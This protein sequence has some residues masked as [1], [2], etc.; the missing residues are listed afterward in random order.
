MPARADTFDLARLNL[1]S[2]EGRR[3]ELEVELGSFRFG[4]DGYTAEPARV[5]V[6]LDISRMTGNGWSLRLRFD[7]ALGGPCMRCLGEA[8]PSVSVD[9]REVDQPGSG[10]ELESPYVTGEE[11]DV[12]RWAH[13]AFALALPAQIL[14]RPDC[15]GLC[16]E[17]G[18]SLNEATDHAHQPAIDPRWAKLGELSFEDS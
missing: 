15:R 1:R 9:A 13:D 7:A 12:Q 11:L 2:G 5:P 3:I 8:G 10:E 17:C 4:E 16:P 18:V 6:L 14:C